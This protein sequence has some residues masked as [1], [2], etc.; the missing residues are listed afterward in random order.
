MVHAYSSESPQLLHMQ[1][2]DWDQQHPMS[3]YQVLVSQNYLD[4][5]VAASPLLSLHRSLCE[6]DS[7]TNHEE[8]VGEFLS[9]YLEAR[10]FTVIKQA[11]PLD[12][13]TEAGGDGNSSSHPSSSSQKPSASSRFNIFA[14]PNG[15]DKPEIILTSHID[16]VPPYIPYSLHEPS[17]SSGS[18]GKGGDFKREDVRIAGRGTVDA[19]G[20]VASMIAATLSHLSRH[21]ETPIALLFVVSEETGGRGMIHF[22]DSSLNTN[23]PTFHTVIFG[24]PTEHALV[25]GHKGNI[26]FEISAKGAAAHSG[27][28]WLGR[29]AISEI[30]PVLSTI[31]VLG[32]IPESEGGFPSSEKYG[33]TTVNIGVI[34]GGVARNVVPSSAL[35]SVAV[36]LAAGT[37]PQARNIVAE[38]VNRAS[39][40]NENVTVAY[41][42]HDGYPPVDL[43]ADVEG[44]K[45]EAVNYGTDV[46]NWKIHER[47][48]GRPVKRYLYGPGTIFVAHGDNEALTIGDLE[49]ASEGYERLIQAA[50]ERSAAGI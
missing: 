15:F 5:I 43:D 9:S 42:G 12:W 6:I 40:G 11:V 24:E 26:Q 41:S 36:R 2:D 29:S 21:P 4:D 37:I 19:K 7:T 47:S 45:V 10:N 32:D 28:P 13:E 46:P 44:F 20:S 22:S 8:S 33:R 3:N 48:D 49:K 16:T 23:P 27:Y 18:D 31:D 17:S 30:L 39:D 50:V 34:E 14:Y 35:A 38:A 1:D 25:S